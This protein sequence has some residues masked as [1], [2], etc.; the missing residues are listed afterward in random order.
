MGVGCWV[1]GVGCWVLGVGCW[2]LGVG[3]WVLGVG[4]WVLGVGCWVLGLSPMKWVKNKVELDTRDSTLEETLAELIR[5]FE[6][7]LSESDKVR[8]LVK[9]AK[10]KG[11]WL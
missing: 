5:Q 1:L 8:I 11:R 10:L 7:F 4:C 6:P 9:K 2:V 3:C